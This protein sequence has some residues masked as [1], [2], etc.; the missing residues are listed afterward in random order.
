MD[1]LIINPKEK[2][3]R[4]TD[5]IKTT[6]KKT[7]FER[8]VVG[9][10]GGVDSAAVLSLCARAIGVENVLAVKMPYGKQ[11]TENADLI[12]DSL[13]ISSINVFT[14]DI[15]PIVD[16]IKTQI[17]NPNLEI[18]NSLN[19]I[20][21]GNMMARA[22]MMVLYDLAKQYSAL[23]CGTE[24]KS[25]ELLG[26]YTRFGDEASDMEPIK[27][28]YKTQVYQLAKYLGIPKEIINKK[29]TAGLWEGQTDYGEL[30]FTYNEADEV[31]F[32]VFEKD[33]SWKELK[34]QKSKVK[35]TT[36]NS[37][38]NLLIKIQQRVEGNWFKKETPYKIELR[39]ELK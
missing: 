19:L 21:E 12:I 20:R 35:T 11:E 4:I 3:E 29:P 13:K 18:F 9:V 14:V 26:Y 1:N 2:T 22:R 38:L 6:L 5:F 15:K 32:Q 31:L 25:E 37:K 39:I 34:S 24:N 10:S 27:H 28:L 23:V 8:M 16:I 30:G 36:K 7:G 33:A 17:N